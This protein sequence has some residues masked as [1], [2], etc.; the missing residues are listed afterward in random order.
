MFQ[1]IH[2]AWHSWLLK[3]N[4]I[5]SLSLRIRPEALREVRREL[6]PPLMRFS[7]S[8]A[9]FLLGMRIIEDAAIADE[10]IIEESG[11]NC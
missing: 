7:P 10:F 5:A 2:E 6:P 11:G 1:Q 3:G 9:Q 4:P 8:A